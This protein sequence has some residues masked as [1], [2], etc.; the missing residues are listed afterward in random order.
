MRTLSP[1]STSRGAAPLVSVITMHTVLPALI[2]PFMLPCR[3]VRRVGRR[4]YTAPRQM[5]SVGV[6][7][8]PVGATAL[9][10]G[11]RDADGF[12]EGDGN[13]VQIRHDQVLLF[14]LRLNCKGGPANYGTSALEWPAVHR[15]DF[16]SRSPR[17]VSVHTPMAYS[18]PCL[19]FFLIPGPLILNELMGFCFS[20]T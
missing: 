10:C 17:P 15:P 11:S 9:T 19:P 4:C 16:Y 5:R 18:T 7:P 1:A 6:D 2:R 12:G 20:L 3:S 14:R 8:A 13:D